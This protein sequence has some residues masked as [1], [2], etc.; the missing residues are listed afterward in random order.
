MPERTLCVRN[1]HED[2]LDDNL[3]AVFEIRGYDVTKAYAFHDPDK[4]AY[5]QGE[6]VFLCAD[7]ARDA[8][9][10]LDGMTVLGRRLKLVLVHTTYRPCKNIAH[11]Q[12]NC[13]VDAADAADAA[14]TCTVG[15]TIRVCGVP[16]GTPECAVRGALEVAGT[17][18]KKTKLFCD[19][20]GVPLGFAD[21]EFETMRDAWV[22]FDTLHD[23]RLKVGGSKLTMCIAQHVLVTEAVAQKHKRSKLH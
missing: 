23:T 17:L 20:R 16:A 8:L 15:R 9:A 19:A 6:V 13:V 2:M 14:E 3:R 5:G 11:T 4:Y 18:V 10:R 21:V 7:E 22:A 12:S 1:L